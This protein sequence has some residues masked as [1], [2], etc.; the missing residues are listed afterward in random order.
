MDVAEQPITLGRRRLGPGAFLSH[1]I[2]PGIGQG[3]R[4]VLRE[5]LQQLGIVRAEDPP[6]V[7]AEHHACAYDAPAPFQRHADDAA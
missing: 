7:P 5:Q 1:L 4:R 6:L 2:H 3:D